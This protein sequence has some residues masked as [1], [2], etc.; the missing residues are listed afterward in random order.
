MISNKRMIKQPKTK[1]FKRGRHTHKPATG[2][3]K[4]QVL[5]GNK[6]AE[7]LH[8]AAPPT[9]L[10]KQLEAER[11][12]KRAEHEAERQAIRDA[13]YL[14]EQRIKYQ[15]EIEM[16]DMKTALSKVI[17][18]WNADE[19]EEPTQPAA[20]AQ[21]TETQA[22]TPP[23]RGPQATVSQ[24]VFNYIRDVPGHTSVHYQNVLG[25][26]GYNKGTVGSLITQ[27]LRQGL[28]RKGEGRVL[29][30][31]RKTYVPRYSVVSTSAN[32]HPPKASTYEQAEIEAV[33]MPTARPQWTP[34]DYPEA[35]TVESVVDKLNI[36]QARAVYDELRKLLGVV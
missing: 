30:V 23:A 32:R 3:V 10:E 27:F 18:S 29:S 24:V 33:P 1:T 16:A 7:L 2:L 26:D 12:L 8:G 9:E 36:R 35:W 6:L 13:A 25:V 11:A 5:D 17:N 34:P 21:A 19:P 4:G 31:T 28:L 22:T 14:E 15:K 20:E